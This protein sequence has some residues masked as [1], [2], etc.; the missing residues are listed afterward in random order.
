MLDNALKFSPEGG[1]VR[2]DLCEREQKAIFSITDSGPGIKPEETERVFDV[3]SPREIDRQIVGSGMSMALARAI[4]QAHDGGLTF[5]SEPHKETTCAGWLPV[6]KAVALPGP[7]TR[8][9]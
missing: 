9:G 4:M 7:A 6:H 3:F 5:T 8:S 1:D 2:V